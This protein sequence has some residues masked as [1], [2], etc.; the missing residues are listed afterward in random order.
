[1]AGDLIGLVRVRVG[2]MPDT[3]SKS[4]LFRRQ[5][6]RQ[7]DYAAVGGSCRGLRANIMALHII[8]TDKRP[9][10]A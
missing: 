7:E 9:A 10:I 5:A 1:M 6:W 4:G 2:D 3:Y 8:P